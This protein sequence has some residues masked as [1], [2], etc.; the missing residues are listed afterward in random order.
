[1]IDIRFE[2][3]GRKVSPDRVGSEMEK[4]ILK[5]VTE[6]IRKALTSV[7]CA[8]YGQRPRVTLK[9]RTVDALSFHIEG[10]CQAL[11]EEAQKKLK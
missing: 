5:E 2:I 8:E 10:C 6:K 11:I 9:G 7:T 3:G 1:M 4:A